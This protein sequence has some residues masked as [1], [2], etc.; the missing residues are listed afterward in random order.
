MKKV[1]LIALALSLFAAPAFAAASWVSGAAT[2][3]TSSGGQLSVQLSNNVQL[4]YQAATDGSTFAAASYH[5]RGTRTYASSSGDAK[6]YYQN[7]TAV[8]SPS[9]PAVGST[10]D[11]SAWTAL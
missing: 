5:T 4:D 6:I 11:S 2:L 7:A 1:L 8:A 9:A 3:G 10:M